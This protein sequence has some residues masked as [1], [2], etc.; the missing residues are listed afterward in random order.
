[1][2]DALSAQ[3]S[4]QTVAEN[5]YRSIKSDLL[6]GELPPGSALLTRDLL[7]RYE[8]GIS[9]LREALARLVGEQ[10][11][12][13]ASHRGVRVPRPSISD[14]EDVYRIRI[15]L[16]REALGLALQFGDDDWEADIIATCHRMEKAPL[17]YHVADQPSAVMEWEARHRAFHFSLIKAAPSPRLL[18]LIDQMVDQ[19]ER[20]RALRLSGMDRAKIGQDLVAEH[21]SLMELVLA[22]DPA[23]LDFLATHLDRTRLAVSAILGE[24]GSP[25]KANA[26]RKAKS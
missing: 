8:C 3:P 13:A 15:A 1:M 12:E 4:A 2:S 17:P 20:Y 11:L 14:V 10:F 7:A 9:P 23:S 25:G 26:P 16:E 6:S 22:R 18:R 24:A 19:T 21:R 5:V